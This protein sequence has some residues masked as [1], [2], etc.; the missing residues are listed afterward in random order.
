VLYAGLDIGTTNCRCL[1]V[2]EEGRSV[3][4]ASTEVAVEFG[5]PD[6]AEV[7]PE[8]WWNA[9]CEVIGA[10]LRGAERPA[11]EVAAVGL[12]GLMHA[13]VLIGTDA[14]PLGS[15]QLWMDQRCTPQAAALQARFGSSHR[16]LDLRGSVSAPKLAWIAA[17]APASIDAAQVVLLPK[18]FVRM[19]LTG[20]VATDRSD[21]IGTGLFDPDKGA[22]MED[23]AQAAGVRADQLPPVR[24]AS[25]PGGVISAKAA[26]ATG[27]AEGTPVA[28]GAADTLCT[29]L[30]AGQ[31]EAGRLLVYL[32]TAAWVAVV[33]GTDEVSGVR[34]SD[35]GATT[36]TGAALRWVRSLFSSQA[37]PLSYAAL[38]ELAAGAPIG[39]AGITFLPHLMGERGPEFSPS[40]RG[41]WQGLT[42]AH[43]RNH[44]VRAV[45]GE[46][47]ILAMLAAHVAAEGAYREDR[48]A[49]VEV[50]EGL[51]FDGIDSDRG[52]PAVGKGE[53]RSVTILAHPAVTRAAVRDHT[54]VRAQ[55]ALHRLV[56]DPFVEH[57]L[58]HTDSPNLD[59]PRPRER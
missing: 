56:T 55:A 28:T 33:E 5:P 6:R 23:V 41:A 49:G 16:R 59:R 24:P 52:D 39:S 29:R 8:H 36:A 40:A 42:L 18:D 25:A 47:P 19:R 20:D 46:L 26:A 44:L 21:A 11:R 31:V 14:R 7:C 38:D 43:G 10:A 58:F 4:V 50:I 34:A 57:R 35:A 3:A 12:S 22:W 1:L 2:D 51:F 9:T 37:D 45:M 30:G 13:P 48:R 17:H 15:A 54:I 32:G 27:L 53:E